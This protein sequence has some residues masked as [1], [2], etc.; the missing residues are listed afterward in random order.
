MSSRNAVPGPEGPALPHLYR[1]YRVRGVTLR[2]RIVVPPMCQYSCDARDGMANSWHL[3]HLGTRAVGGAGCI[4]FEAT[5]VAPE[6]RITPYDIGIWSD[7]QA[8]ALAPVVAFVRAQGAAAA[9][10][11]GHA[12]RK[13]SMGRPWTGGRAVSDADGGWTPIAPSAI[14]FDNHHRAPREM[15]EGDIAGVVLQALE[16]RLPFGVNGFGIGFVTRVEVLDVRGVTAVEERGEG[17][18]GVRVLARHKAV[19]D[20]LPGSSPAAGD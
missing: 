19:P 15:T 9:I 8:D 10:Q 20:K 12:G 17:E 6:G 4:I 3:V 18:S 13:A 14:P 2:N 7:A 16:E 1:P 11:L 5:G